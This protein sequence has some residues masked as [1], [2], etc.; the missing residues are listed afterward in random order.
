MYTLGLY[1]SNLP[2]GEGMPSL[3]IDAL[4]GLLSTTI[5]INGI[6]AGGSVIRSLVELPAWKRINLSGFYEYACAADLG[7]GLI[8]YPSIGIAAAVLVVLVTIDGYVD[9]VNLTAMTF[10]WISLILAIA[11]TITTTRAAPNMLSLRK[12]ANNYETIRVV[13]DR[14]KKWQDLRAAL[15]FLNL[16][17]LMIAMVSLVT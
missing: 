1:R 15:Q 8:L 3:D 7:R 13:F 4:I 14:F 9:G 17:T 6:L 2:L 11:H 10:L 12:A 16:L 5:V